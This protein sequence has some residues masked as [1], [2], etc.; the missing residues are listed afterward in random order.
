MDFADFAKQCQE[1]GV[2]PNLCDP[3]TFEQSADGSGS[4]PNLCLVTASSAP[5]ADQEPSV[6]AVSDIGAASAVQ[7]SASIEQQL[8][9]LTQGSAMIEQQLAELTQKSQAALVPVN[10]VRAETPYVK[11]LFTEFFV[12]SVKKLNAKPMA[13]VNFSSDLNCQIVHMTPP[14]HVGGVPILPP[15]QHESDANALVV[16]WQEGLNISHQTLVQD[17]AALAAAFTGQGIVSG[18][19][20]LGGKPMAFVNFF[21][22][23]LVQAVLAKPPMQIAG[24][25]VLPPRQHETEARAIVLRWERSADLAQAD[26]VDH[27]DHCFESQIGRPLMTS[28]GPH[29][30]PSAAMPSAGMPML[31]KAGMP[32]LA[33]AGMPMLAKAGTPMLAK[34]GMPNLAKAGML[35]LAK[36]GMPTLGNAAPSGP[37][38]GNAN[39]GLAAPGRG[40]MSFPGLVQQPAAAQLAPANLLNAGLAPQLSQANLLNAGLAPQ[41]SEAN[42]LNAGL[43]PQFS[44]ASLLNAGLALQFKRLGEEVPTESNKRY[45]QSD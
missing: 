38:G 32:M 4:D 34:V 22:P 19:R 5:D 23:T 10:P 33:T 42:L 31:A 29:V 35:A 43:A 36:A 20:K 28:P 14:S 1:L 18:V 24:V 13:M 11:Q 30:M 39:A 45:R 41:L 25:P 15:R 40:L 9:E 21:S 3:S 44:Q 8:A 2:D 17:F 16:R 27:F 6:G 37:R 12:T 26:I 7:G